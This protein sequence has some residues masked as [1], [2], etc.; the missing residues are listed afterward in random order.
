MRRKRTWVATAAVAVLAAAA[1]LGGRATA[2]GQSSSGGGTMT[3]LA[4]AAPSGS[5]DPAIDYTLQEWQLLIITHD[6]LIAFKRVAGKAGTEKVPDL[7]ESIPKPT[8][9][10]KTYTFK[11]RKNIHYAN[12]AVVKPSDFKST[13]ERMFKVHG[14]TAGT[15]YNV[16]VGSDKCLKKPATCDLSRGIV[17]NDKATKQIKLVRNKYFKEWSKDAQPKGNPDE[18]VM[19][20]GLSVEAEVTQ[21]ENGQ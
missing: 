3:L 19:K 9:G 15:F 1:I 5:P 7:A 8:D 18:I 14:P 4:R 11:V 17:P 2:G 20:F 21:V 10:G 12:G 13:F 6:G 16:F